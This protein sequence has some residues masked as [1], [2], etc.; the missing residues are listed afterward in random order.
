MSQRALDRYKDAREERLGKND[1]RRIRAERDKARS[2]TSG[3]ARRWPFELLQNAH[4]AGPRDGASSVTVSFSAINQRIIFR[5]NG[6]PFAENDLAALLSG[7]SNK[8][9]E[10]TVT[11]GRFG[12]GFLVSHVL[13]PTI[14]LQGLMAG[15]PA[16]ERFDIL[17]D[18]G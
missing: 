2:P 18:R 14:H 10:S 3:A 8:E 6:R 17:L 9:Y 7:G 15:E 4:D 1:A 11:T 13:S 12:T 16:Y 5:H